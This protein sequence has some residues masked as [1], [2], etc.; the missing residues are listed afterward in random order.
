M[1]FTAL[2]CLLLTSLVT[3][4]ACGQDS[5]F[6][7]ARQVTRSITMDPS[8]SPDGKQM[9]YITVVAGVEQLFS[10]NVD[11]TDVR[12]I[13][14]D[15]FDHEDPAWSHDGRKIAF[16]SDAAGLQV[17]SL[18]NTDGTA[19][20]AL[21][22]REVH[23]I[24]PSWTPDSRAVLYCTTD[25]LDPPRKNA[26]DIYRIELA[27]RQ[28]TRL[29]SGGINTYPALSPDGKRL[30]F[31]KIIDG[32]NSEVFVANADGSSQ[33]NLTNDPAFDGW[34]SWSPDGTRIAFA[35]NRRGNQQIFVMDPDGRNV[36]PLVHK[37]GRATAP[38]WAPDGRTL[39][40]PICTRVDGLVGCEIFAA[41]LLPADH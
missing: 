17:V 27:T 21:T 8:L 25:D 29:V 37:E 22:P 7:L 39:Y 23:A 24:H 33:R 4:A 38:T 1:R 19:V 36:R 40:F 12:Q 16:V 15:T 6:A 20:E 10:A 11:G 18:M 31:R 34:P 28:V 26:A 41:S 2:S 30:A 5:P 3:P 13:T 32:T 14:H 9:V 35:S